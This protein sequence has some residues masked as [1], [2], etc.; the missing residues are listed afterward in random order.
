MGLINLDPK[1]QNV[2]GDTLFH[3]EED[4]NLGTRLELRMRDYTRSNVIKHFGVS[5]TEFLE[6]NPVVC[7]QMV[8][9]SYK[10]ENERAK[11]IDSLNDEVE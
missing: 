9:I 4:P 8:N 3:K 6:Y 5:F 7:D 10:L 11:L 2:F 1:K